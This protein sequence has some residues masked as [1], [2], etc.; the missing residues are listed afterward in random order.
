[1]AAA[2]SAAHAADIVHRDFKSS[3]V[4]LLPPARSRDPLRVV[5]TDFGLA[6]SV[7]SDATEDAA[8][9]AARRCGRHARL[10]G[11]GAGGGWSR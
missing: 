2:L 6:Y 11:A 9:T 7:A 8:I 10:H 4:M 5:V 3:N 1:M